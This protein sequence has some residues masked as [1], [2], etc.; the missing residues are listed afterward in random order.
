MKGT[1][2]T[3]SEEVVKDEDVL[4]VIQ[5]NGKVRSKITVS[6]NSDDEYIRARALQDAKVQQYID[7]KNLE[8]IVVVPNRLVSIVVK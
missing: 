8:K 7:G 5:V 3:Y 6:A 4:I 1:W 2:P